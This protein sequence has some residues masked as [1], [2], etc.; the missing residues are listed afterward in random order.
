MPNVC[1][2]VLSGSAHSCQ[3]F[4]SIHAS[5]LG[6]PSHSQSYQSKITT[7][8]CVNNS[9]TCCLKLFC[10]WSELSTVERKLKNITGY[11]IISFA[12]AISLRF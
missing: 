3:F 5:I 7:E 11:N 2:S 10:V 8:A 9:I 12:I 4:F 6:I 1:H